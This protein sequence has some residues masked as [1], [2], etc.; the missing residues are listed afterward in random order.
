[1]DDW[2]D[3][4]NIQRT[5]NNMLK[6]LIT[7]EDWSGGATLNPSF[8]RKNQY[9]NSQGI[10]HSMREGYITTAPSKIEM[11]LSGTHIN[12]PIFAMC[13]LN[14]NFFGG[15]GGKIFK[16][17]DPETIVLDHTTSGGSTITSMVYHDGFMYYADVAGVIGR[18]NVAFDTYAD[19]WNNTAVG[20]PQMVVASDNNLWIGSGSIVSKFD[21][22]AFTL[23][24]LDLPS[25]YVIATVK[26]FGTQYIAICATSTYQLKSK[27]F[28]WDRLSSSWNNEVSLHE[29]EIYSALAVK[30]N[31]WILAGSYNMSL[32]I[33]P[34]GSLSPIKVKQF[35][36]DSNAT[37]ARSYANAMDYRD[38]RVYFGVSDSDIH[39][40]RSGV[41]LNG[42]YSMSTDL[43]KLDLTCEYAIDPNINEIN[44]RV[45]LVQMGYPYRL[46]SFNSFLSP[47]PT[48]AYRLYGQD[49]T[50]IVSGEVKSFWYVAPPGTRFLFDGFGGEALQ[51]LTENY[52]PTVTLEVYTNLSSSSSTPI[53]SSQSGSFYKTK[54]FECKAIMFKVTI[55]DSYSAG[56][57]DTDKIFLKS[58][59]ATGKLIADPR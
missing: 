46:F 42:V 9:F 37:S 32:Y 34:F 45:S 38:G 35:N 13:A 10:D 27:I 57:N 59:Y 54:T 55:T 33:L 1:M 23:N 44:Q 56:D 12:A 14:T 48:P 26:N 8:G 3:A 31:L 36:Q 28:I 24:A 16:Q 25:E 5:N 49:S 41:L 2:Y 19:G 40:I 52:T 6:P 53:F 39:S 50:G 47:Y 21:G 29:K 58:I 20:N 15:S 43:T 22:T 4:D 11:N 7:I 51:G 18:Y 30:G 17:T